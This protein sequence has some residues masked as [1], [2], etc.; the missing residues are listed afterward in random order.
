M[1]DLV[2]FWVPAIPTTREITGIIIG[3]RLDNLSITGRGEIYEV[4]TPEDGILSLTVGSLEALDPCK[5]PKN[6]V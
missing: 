5:K 2:R 1:G 6:V 4:L 3:I